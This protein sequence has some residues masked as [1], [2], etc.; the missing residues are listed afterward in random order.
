MTTDTKWTVENSIPDHIKN[1]LNEENLSSSNYVSIF[2]QIVS[3]LK[4]QKRTGWVDH[5]ILEC[6]SIS[7]HMYRMGI[8]TL[9]IKDPK[10]DTNQC[11]KIALIHDIAES[12]VGDITP[13]DPVTKEEKHRRELETINYLSDLV[14]KYD[15]ERGE[16]ILKFWLDYEEIR[17]PEARYVKDI[18]KYEMLLQCFEYEKKFQGEKKLDQFWSAR[19][20][21]KTDE[22]K[23]WT[24][25]L[26]QRRQTFWETI[27]NK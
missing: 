25:D 17:T 9:L 22:V 5:G 18:D 20:S 3:L 13:F 1:L 14:K 7:D 27:S 19:T 15:S 8:T 24:E 11:V 10:I 21:V 2:L 6:E 12:L 16:E 26:W 23:G 4:S